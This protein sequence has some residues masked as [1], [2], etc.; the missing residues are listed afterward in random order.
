MTIEDK[1]DALRSNLKLNNDDLLGFMSTVTHHAR[2]HQW[3][4]GGFVYSFCKFY[5]K[6]LQD[7]VHYLATTTVDKNN[8]KDDE[9]N[10]K[11]G[12]VQSSARGISGRVQSRGKDGTEEMSME[13]PSASIKTADFE[14]V[15]LQSVNNDVSSAKE[16]NRSWVSYI[17][18][19]FGLEW[20]AISANGGDP[21]NRL[22]PAASSEF[23]SSGQTAI[24]YA[25]AVACLFVPC[26]LA[27]RLAT[28]LS[29][30]IMGSRE[31]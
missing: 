18:S 8:A 7:I 23:E 12:N 16:S 20:E 28:S 29:A 6:D 11:G 2:T 22:P 26:D 31:L 10:A 27:V 5:Q 30:R 17:S 13:G 15:P 14:T 21:Y 4:E 24:G 25:R 3:E 9:N 1:V 19:L